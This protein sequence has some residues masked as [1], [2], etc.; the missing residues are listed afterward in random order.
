MKKIKEDIDKNLPQIGKLIEETG[1]DILNIMD[2]FL[3]N[4]AKGLEKLLG[5]PPSKRKEKRRS[6]LF[7]H[8]TN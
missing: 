5:E 7:T 4:V 6:H 1:G 3:Q 8:S 2:Q